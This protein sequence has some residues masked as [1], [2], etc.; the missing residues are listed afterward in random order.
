MSGAL[1]QLSPLER[2]DITPQPQEL[3]A[4]YTV[5]DESPVF[6]GDSHSPARDSAPSSE[7]PPPAPAP[8]TP[9]RPARAR[10]ADGPA[11]PVPVVKPLDVKPPNP[12]P[13]NVKP[14]DVK[15]PVVRP[16]VVQPLA[17]PPVV[18]PLAAPPAY[19]SVGASPMFDDPG[20]PG[21]DRRVV[22][23]ACRFEHGSERCD[24]DPVANLLVTLTPDGPPLLDPRTGPVAH[25]ILALDVSASMNRTDKY[26]LLTEALAGML[27]DLKRP[28]SP[29]VL[30][31][32]VLFAYGS[33]TVFRDRPASSL[34][35]RDVLREIDRSKLRFGRYTDV[36]GAL[37]R[38]GRI[39]LE[40][41]KRCKAMP[42]RICVLTDGRPQDMDGAR[43]V[44]EILR[45]SPVDVD[46]L[47][48]GSDAD[49]PALQEL[50]SGG[51][52]G[53]VKQIR[54]DTIAEAFGHIAE[55]AARLISNRAVFDFELARGVVGGA[56]F[57]YRPA[58]H[59]FGDNAFVDGRRFHMDLGTLEAGRRYALFF[60]IRLPA[61][62]SLETEVGRITLRIPGHG[63]P[64]TFET[65]VSVSRHPGN[66]T[67]TPDREVQA[68]WDVLSA[69]GTTDPRDQ[70]RALRTRRK[71]Y[72]AE[73]RDPQL[74]RAIDVA[75]AELEAH[76]TLDRLAPEQQAAIL[77]HTCS[78]GR[79]G[80]PKAAATT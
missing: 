35:P 14:L 7:V 22:D 6:A 51:R 60:Q 29:D 44:M 68:A 58:R 52:G 57:R 5:L 54:S 73:R 74:L 33:E 43:K 48:F 10:N 47:A 13:P 75:I 18:Q 53:T 79:A 25:V 23:L 63:G 16:V 59:R 67:G 55:T 37:K 50:V 40:Q 38:S 42:V 30:I 15:A 2:T 62:K 56:A 45:K 70:L 27:Y 3:D 4:W 65:H 36:V 78:V 69:L 24:D 11:L 19:E 49:V 20:V 28:G 72:E 61:S 8:A 26:P 21:V 64:R 77:S 71:L 9:P 31:S 34:E 80:K 1:P 39:A 12:T 41:I 46:G 76:G 66:R 17:S 32:V